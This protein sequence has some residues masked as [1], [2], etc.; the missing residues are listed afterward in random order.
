MT[1]DPRKLLQEAR[2]MI[3]ARVDLNTCFPHERRVITRIDA[4]LATGE[5]ISV[6]DKL[7]IQRKDYWINV[8]GGDFATIGRV[9][10]GFNKEVYWCL[11]NGNKSNDLAYDEVSHYAEITRPQLPKKG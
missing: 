4:Y 11:E 1:D 2:E 3:L 10:L 9:N 6:K 5:W 7:P 8:V